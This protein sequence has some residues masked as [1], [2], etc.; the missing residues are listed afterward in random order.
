MLHR[1]GLSQA[2]AADL[3]SVNHR[4][5]GYWLAG[6]MSPRPEHWQRLVDLCDR[7]DRAADEAIALIHQQ[8][9]DRGETEG[10]V[11][12]RLAR[13]DKEA[14]QLGWPSAAAHLAVLR[15]VVEWA[16]AGVTV[17]PVYP[18]EDAAADAAMLAP[19]PGARPH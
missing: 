10:T 11:T 14:H 5:L 12:I 9:L 13:T 17:T 6:R 4:T 19:L 8:V 18:G 7:Q 3:L 15:R 2:D 16:P 1:C